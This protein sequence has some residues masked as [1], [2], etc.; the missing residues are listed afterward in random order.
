MDEKNIQNQIVHM[1]SSSIFSVFLEMKEIP[2]DTNDYSLGNYK[3]RL[4]PY[5][6]VIV[7]LETIQV[8]FSWNTHC[9]S[10]CCR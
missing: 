7:V 10:M 9:I 3:L 1:N 6:E 4:L 2:S 5:R 8:L